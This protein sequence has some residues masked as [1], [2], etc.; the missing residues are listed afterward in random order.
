MYGVEVLPFAT[1]ISDVRLME[2]ERERHPLKKF[3]RFYRFYLLLGMV[4]GEIEAMG[5]LYPPYRGIFS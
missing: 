3:G 4:L 5:N 1:V 2:V